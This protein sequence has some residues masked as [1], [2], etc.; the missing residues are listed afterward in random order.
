M[1]PIIEKLEKSKVVIIWQCGNEDAPVAEPA[2]RVQ[3]YS[4][5]IEI[6]QE[7]DAILINY[8]TVDALIKVLKE[9]L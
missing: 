5:S 2:L 9:K 7:G 8:E 3:F 1:K 4:D 6:K